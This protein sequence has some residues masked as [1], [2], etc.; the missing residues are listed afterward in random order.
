MTQAQADRP[1]A[2]KGPAIAETFQVHVEDAIR[3]SH[4]TI[5][6]V[7]AGVPAAADRWGIFSLVAGVADQ[8]PDWGTA[9]SMRDAALRKFIVAEPLA[10]SAFASVIA[11]YA[12]MTWKIEGP[13]QS[14]EAAQEMVNSA[15]WGEG[16]QSFISKFAMDY[17]TQDK[18]AFVEII[19]LENNPSSPVI[20]FRSLDAAYCWCTGDPMEPVMFLD[21]VSGKYFKLKWYQV[22][23]A[24]QT[25]VHHPMFFGLQYSALTRVLKFAQIFRNVLQYVDEKTGGRHTRALHVIGGVAKETLEAELARMQGQANSQGLTRYIQ[26]SIVAAI[27]PEAKPALVTLELASLPDGF[28]FE[29]YGKWY[30]ICISMGLLDDYGEFAPLPSGNLGTAT[31]S[32]VMDEKSK[33]KGQ[34]LFRKTIETMMNRVVLPRNLTFKYDETDLEEEERE[35]LIRKTRAEARGMMITNREIDHV[36]ARELAIEQGDLPENLVA[37]IEERQA[38]EDAAREEARNEV[39]NELAGAGMKVPRAPVA[40]ARGRI[41][42]RVSPATQDSEGGSSSGQKED[43]AGPS[44]ERLDAEGEAASM[45]ADALD[46]IYAKLRKR[47]A[48][49]G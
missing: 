27:D 39:F 20:A 33:Q 28:A 46:D 31:Q 10:A 26:P 22:Y 38:Q 9:P 8:T 23:H 24:T 19:R 48:S 36:A 41:S 40:D 3:K 21:R 37:G 15:E 45:V 47:L 18:G 32:E 42:S 11:K 7:A 25:P 34:G 2:G 35:A 16:W 4:S 44:E 17:L 49:E 30:M 5:D 13:P 6:D 29:D 1:A 12:Q 14:S 43:R